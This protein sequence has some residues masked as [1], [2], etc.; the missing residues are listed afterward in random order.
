MSLIKIRYKTGHGRKEYYISEE[1]FDLSS[2]IRLE[3]DNDLKKNKFKENMKE[4]LSSKTAPGLA[5]SNQTPSTTYNNKL[6]SG[7]V[8]NLLDV[9]LEG[10]KKRALDR[11][12]SRGSSF[13]KV[14]HPIAKKNN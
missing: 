11:N 1:R 6:D 4:I 8:E 10:A 13:H 2:M 12:K 9:G 5:N 3:D 14:K 7:A